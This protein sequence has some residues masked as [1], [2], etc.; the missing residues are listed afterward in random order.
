MSLPVFSFRVDANN[1]VRT[2]TY[3]TKSVQYGDGYRQL[4]PAGI[5]N[6]LDTWDLTLPLLTDAV[7]LQVEAF[8]D[9]LGQHKN[10]SWT[11]PRGVEG[12][13]RLTSPIRYQAAGLDRYGVTRTTVVLSIELLSAIPIVG[14]WTSSNIFFPSIPAAQI[15]WKSSALPTLSPQT[16][17][18]ST[19]V[20]RILN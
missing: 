12:I 13:Y 3:R 17:F 10:F 16:T 20:I 4:A 6:K 7:V 14:I 5:N 9:V 11:P 2:N 19:N 8:F 1:A 18:A 15:N